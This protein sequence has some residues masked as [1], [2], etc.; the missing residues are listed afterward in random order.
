LFEAV[1]IDELITVDLHTTA[2][3][4]A[5]RL[6]MTIIPAI[7]VFRP[8]LPTFPAGKLCVVSPDAGGLKRA[9]QFAAAL[10]SPVA[11]MTKSRRGPDQPVLEMLLGDV[12]GQHCLIVDDMASTGRTLLAAADALGR[13]GAA[14]IDAII[15]H[16]VFAP[17]ARE[18]L[19]H[20]P[21]GRLITSDTIPLGEDLDSRIEVHSICAPLARLLA[22]RLTDAPRG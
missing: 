6:P 9:Q 20:S 19:E 13:A 15:T 16:A 3:E 17:G 10:T 22:E 7:D 5:Y 12:R 14:A 21:I 8:Q 2:L 4:S 11:L 1:G 18:R